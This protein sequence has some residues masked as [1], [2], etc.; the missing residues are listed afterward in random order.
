MLLNTLIHYCYIFAKTKVN[1]ESKCLHKSI[2]YNMTYT[3]R[4]L[5]KNIIK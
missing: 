4:K 2:A 5:F 1:T 3:K